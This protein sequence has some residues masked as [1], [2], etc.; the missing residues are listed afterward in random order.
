MRLRGALFLLIACLG[1]AGCTSKSGVEDLVP[2]PSS[3]V[4]SS[5][6][7]PAAPVPSEDVGELEGSQAGDAAAAVP[8]DRPVVEVSEQ[9]TPEL[10][11]AVAFMAPA[12][13]AAASAAIEAGTI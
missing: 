2:R 9:E 4:T 5:I 1:S 7:R 6:S 3:E 11:Q 10:P 13:P 8:Q 12:K